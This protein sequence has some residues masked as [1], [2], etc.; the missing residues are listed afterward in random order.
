MFLIGFYVSGSS[1]CLC[2]ASC[3]T[4]TAPS[5]QEEE[6]APGGSRSKEDT[7]KYCRCCRCRNQSRLPPALSLYSG[8]RITRLFIP[9]G[10]RGSRQAEISQ[11]QSWY[12][13]IKLRFFSPNIQSINQSTGWVFILRYKQGAD[14]LVSLYSRQRY[15][16]GDW[17][18]GLWRFDGQRVREQLGGV[19]GGVVPIRPAAK[20]AGNW[21]PVP[22]VVAATQRPYLLPLLQSHPSSHHCW[23]VYLQSVDTLFILVLLDHFF[24]DRS[25]H[26]DYNSA[27]HYQDAAASWEPLF[28]LLVNLSTEWD[29]FCSIGGQSLAL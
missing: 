6:N 4:P 17:H 23:S 14:R 16:I 11:Q 12:M 8:R 5:G 29:F 22:L 20:A 10:E 9:H 21:T 25:L 28:F 13:L 3:V 18:I 19:F 27:L 24:P 7:V 15:R 1:E 2:Q 26:G